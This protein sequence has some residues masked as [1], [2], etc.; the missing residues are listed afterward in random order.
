MD[1][2]TQIRAVRQYSESFKRQV[3]EEYLSGSI[4]QAALQ[5]KYDIRGKCA[6][7]NWRRQLGYYQEISDDVSNLVVSIPITV[8][9]KKEVK[10]NSELQQRIKDLERQLEDEKLRAE[11]YGRI[12]DKAEKELKIP[13][14]KKPNT[15]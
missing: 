8:T 7:L 2:P 9:K 5:R 11:A 12:I 1:Q 4:T 3:I 14:R 6:I 13:I 15:K 10:S